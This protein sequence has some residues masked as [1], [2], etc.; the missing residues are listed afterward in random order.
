M[1]LIPKLPVLDVS[2]CSPGPVVYCKPQPPRPQAFLG[3][4]RGSGHLK[5]ARGEVQPVFRA[6]PPLVWWGS[7]RLLQHLGLQGL[8]H[9]GVISH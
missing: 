8:G 5:C 2:S 9:E 3:V 1:T 4:S 6:R 7:C